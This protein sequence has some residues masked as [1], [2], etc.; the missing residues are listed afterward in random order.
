MGTLAGSGRWVA[1][2]LAA[3][4]LAGLGLR[5][6]GLSFGLPNV[7]C[8]PDESTLVHRALAIGAGD[9]NPHFFN[10]PSLHFYL[11]AALYGGYYV[12]GLLGGLFANLAEFEAQFLID[13]SFFY[14]LGRGLGMLLGVASVWVLYGIG[15]RLG[16]RAVGL[17]SALFLACSF[18]HVRD[19]HFLTV[20]VPATFYL[21]ISLLLVLRHMGEGR[22]RDLI[23]GAVFLG[24]AAS[25]KYN[26]GLFAGTVLVAAY[27]GA[28]SWREWGVRLGWVL[29]VMGMAFVAGSPYVLLDFAAFWRDLSYER[30]HFVRGHDADLGRGWWYHLGFTLP[31]GLGWPLFVA[32]LVGLGRWVWNRRGEEWA[33]LVGIASYYAVAGS[34]K[35]VFMRYMLPL[36]PLLCVAAGS[37]VAGAGRPGRCRRTAALLVLLLAVPTAWVSWRHSELLARTDTRVLAA[38]WIEEHIPAGSRIALCCGSDYGYP[39][40][41]LDRPAL[42]TRLSELRGAGFAARRQQRLLAL[43]AAMPGPGYELIELRATNPS[44]FTWVWTAYGAKRLLREQ[45]AWIAVHQL[46]GLAYSRLD[47]SFVAELEQIAERQVFLDPLVD[48]QGKR[49]Y[50][51]LDAFYTP[52]SGFAGV[53]RPGPRIAI[54]RVDELQL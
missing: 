19:S 49:L 41:Q 43:G 33:L 14:L 27:K 50:D 2:V 6:W 40:L 28:T 18:L 46:P 11:L 48:D 5:V 31:L 47:S 37:L 22:T 39:Q 12:V 32:A 7:H 54:Y 24:L 30:L 35:V 21:L 10:Y 44:G 42:A 23:L 45:V 17:A 9:P 13:P 36:L 51:P 8:R 1:W 52:V 20:D 15:G 53:E 25:T 38:R 4:L 26:M 29:I 3:I 34:G 16:G